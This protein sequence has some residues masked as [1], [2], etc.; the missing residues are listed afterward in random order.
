MITKAVLIDGLQI[1][2]NKIVSAKDHYITFSIY[3]GMSQDT[4]NISKDN[5]LDHVTIPYSSII[6]IEI[7]TEKQ[8]TNAFG[9][10]P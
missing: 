4:N 5:P 1:T 3:Q 9:F 6:R 7:T 2:I 10:C 8:A